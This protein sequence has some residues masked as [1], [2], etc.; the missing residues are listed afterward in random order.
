MEKHR[1]RAVERTLL[2]TGVLI[3]V[4]MI[5]YALVLNWTYAD[6]IQPAF[7]YAGKQYVPSSWPIVAVTVVLAIVTAWALPQRIRR[8]S[9]AVLWILFVVAIGPSILMSSYL[10][11]VSPGEAVGMSS[12]FAL[13]F[14]VVCLAVRRKQLTKPLVRRVSA[15]SFWLILATFSGVVYAYL[16]LSAGLSLRFL[17]LVDVYDVRQDYAETLSTAGVLGYLVSTQA[18]V[19][20]PL[21]FSRGIY[22]RRWRFIAIAVVGQLV[23]YSGTGFKTVL[24]S[25]PSLLIV[26]WLF[27]ANLRPRGILLLWGATGVVVAAAAL[28]RIDGGIVWSSLFARRFLMT[29]AQLSAQYV[30]F[31][32][33]S[34]PEMLSHSVL[35]PFFPNPL[36]PYGPARMIGF[37]V[38]GSPAM[39][40][41]ANL[42]A[43]GFAHFGWFGVGGIS[44]L[45]ILFLRVL[46]RAAYGLPTAVSALV[47]V[48]PSITLSN[49]SMLTAMFSHG[50]IA[51]VVMLAVAP[52]GNWGLKAGTSEQ[53]T[54]SSTRAA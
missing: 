21:I 45:L 29:P 53:R 50:L 12:G 33:N 23:L 3:P 37:V 40:A 17:A 52:H 13:A 46:D 27:R 32:S 11:I 54:R 2:R 28:D 43:D 31:Y 14:I 16:A 6:F 4:T 1:R 5:V 35:A 30:E 20:N 22:S 25:I 49:T 36:Y 8:P 10:G 41:N 15:T 34:P 9:A 7:A 38:S 26:A 47:V 51:M 19:V 48:M 39:S 44:L 24:F 18:N 42:F